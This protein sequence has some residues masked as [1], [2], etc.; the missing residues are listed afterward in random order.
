MKKTTQTIVIPNAA[1]PQNVGDMAILKQLLRLLRKK[2]PK[3]RIIIHCAN[4]QL[5]TSG[6][7]I[8]FKPTVSYWALFEKTDVVSCFIRTFIVGS[9]FLRVRFGLPVP[10][11]KIPTE[12][13]RDYKKADRIV[14][15]GGGYLRAQKGLKQSLN[16]FSYLATAYAIT[17]FK[18]VKVMAS[19]SI[20]PFASRWQE[21]LTCKLLCRLDVII[22]REK[23][24]HDLLKRNGLK[25]VVISTDLALLRSVTL[26][27]RATDS[28][29]IGFT[30]RPWSTPKM[31]ERVVTSLVSSFVR[32]GKHKQIKIRPIVQVSAP[33]YGED[34]STCAKEIARRLRE[35][36]IRVLPIRYVERMEEPENAY[37]DLDLLVG[38]RMHSNIIAATSGV[39]FVAIA[40]EYK[41]KGIFEQLDSSEYVIDFDE[42]TEK[43]LYALIEKAYSKKH[44]LRRRMLA[45]IDRLQKIEEARIAQAM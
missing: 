39:P 44:T 22:A 24:T 34:D 2:F 40:Y 32:L 18:A 27:R 15:V 17:S 25:H 26:Q 41:T 43:K 10:S 19:V 4:P 36:G 33:L 16:L 1:S 3:A 37:K 5:H 23:Y 7:G 14:F 13:F 11:G 28:K 9:S 38:M 45:A 6:K 20:G 31:H 42:V 29:V 8:S 12:I 30:V 21:W 35:K